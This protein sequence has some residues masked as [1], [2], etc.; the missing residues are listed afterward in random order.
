MKEDERG[1]VKDMVSRYGK[2]IEENLLHIG[3]WGS[4]LT[5]LA[6]GIKAPWGNGSFDMLIAV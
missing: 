3:L 5:W 2:M 4:R 1:A 6:L